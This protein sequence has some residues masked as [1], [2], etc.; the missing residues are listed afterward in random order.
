[1]RLRAWDKRTI[2]G[3][4][5]AKL[6]LEEPGVRTAARLLTKGR[7]AG[8]KLSYV[9]KWERFTGF[10]TNEQRRAGRA[11]RSSLP[12]SGR[13]VLA[14]LGFLRE[15]GVKEA[16]L[17]PY[18]SAIN[19]AHADSGLPKPAV[20]DHIK[21]L[22][23]GYA[24]EDG[25]A[26]K[27][28][29]G[30]PVPAA[31]IFAVAK[32]GIDTDEAEVLRDAAATVL[33]FLFMHRGDTGEHLQREDI[34]IEPRGI[35]LNPRSKTCPR[36]EAR[37]CF[38]PHDPKYDPD[39]VVYKLLRRWSDYG[40]PY[41]RPTD[42]FWAL[43]HEQ[44]EGLKFPA[45]SIDSWLKASLRRVS[46]TPPP[47]QKW[48]GHCLRKGGAST[49]I[50]IG[51]SLNYILIYGQWKTLQSAQR[52]IEY[53]TS[54]DWAAFLF[55]GWMLPRSFED[56]LLPLKENGGARAMEGTRASSV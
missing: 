43:P 24:E 6:D 56:C 1:M 17:N 31:A 55:F 3:A 48:T 40:G 8:T 35:G 23:R 5:G 19:Q 42:L 13:T 33:A 54:A 22:R 41:Q 7:R 26:V 10:C 36:N 18:V 30:T 37:P 38:R 44:K 20:G 11:P 12:A 50:A 34:S 9:G 15:E 4:F 45:S 46:W 52:Y 47:G 14:Y 53:L 27:P 25:I 2:L 49:A 32:L 28:V 51:V 16:S 29:K 39:A 21:L